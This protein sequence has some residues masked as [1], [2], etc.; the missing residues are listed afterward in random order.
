[1]KK[2]FLI[3][4][5]LVSAVFAQRRQTIGEPTD[6][7]FQN[8]LK[9]GT[10][11]YRMPIVKGTIGQW[12]QIDASGNVTFVNLD[13]TAVDTTKW[14][15]FIRDHETNH[16]AWILAGAI[17]DSL[18]AYRTSYK[19]DTTKIDTAQYGKFVR[20]H[21]SATSG[22][23]G[24]GDIE[25]VTAGWGI[26]GGGTTGTVTVTADTGANKLAT[27][28]D[29]SLKQNVSDTTTKDATRYWVGLQSYLTAETGDISNVSVTSPITGGGSSGSV[30]IG[31]DTTTGVTKLATQGFVE[32]KNYLTAETGDISN[33][34]VNAPITGGGSSGSVTISADTSAGANKLATQYYV[35]SQRPDSTWEKITVNDS[36]II[37]ANSKF[38]YG[39][40]NPF[41]SYID[42]TGRIGIGRVPYSYLDMTNYNDLTKWFLMFA[43]DKYRPDATD[44]LVAVVTGSGKWVFNPS[45][46]STAGD[47]GSTL[48]IGGGVKAD[49]FRTP[50]YKL[51]HADGSSG[52]VLVT[53]GSGTISFAARATAASIT[54]S[55]DLYRT[56]YKLDTTKIDT[57]QYGKFVRD[58]QSSGGGSGTGDI[59]GVTAGW[60]LSGGGTTG[61]VTLAADTSSGKL[62]THYTL[63]DSLNNYRVSQVVTIDSP[64]VGINDTSPTQALDVTG[65][66]YVSGSMNVAT[67]LGVKTDPAYNFH[68]YQASPTAN[69]VLL[70]VG[71]SDDAN[72]FGV[73]EDGDVTFDGSVTGASTLTISNTS[74]VTSLSGEDELWLNMDSDNNDADVRYIAFGKNSTAISATE[75]MRLTEAG[76]LGIGTTVPGA[77]V[78]IN[79]NKSSDTLL[80][81]RNDKV[82]RDSS[83][84][85]T[86]TGGGVFTGNVAI[87]TNVDPTNELYVNGDLYVV[88]TLYSGAVVDHTA[89]PE[90]SVDLIRSIGGTDGQLNHATLPKSIQ[91][92][93]KEERWKRKSDNYL[94]PREF[95]P[96]D[97]IWAEWYSIA[98]DTTYDT[99][100]VEDEELGQ[101][102][103]IDT[104]YHEGLVIHP[105]NSHEDSV[106]YKGNFFKFTKIDT[107]RDVG[108]MLSLLTKSVQYEF[109]NSDSVKENWNFKTNTL[110]PDT[111]IIGQPDSTY[112][113][114]FVLSDGE[115]YSRM[116]P[117]DA[118]ARVASSSSKKKDI[119]DYVI[120]IEKVK[121][122]KPKKYKYTDGTQEH[123]GFIA[124]EMN[125]A[126]GITQTNEIDYNSVIVA[127]WE[128]VRQQQ[129]RI[130]ALEKKVKP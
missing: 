29:I 112:N 116:L 97:S 24:T 14:G 2:I 17:K 18:D 85:V 78:E 123:T 41:Y 74:G 15:K 93:I 4:L 92:E 20:D 45:M 101:I 48:N 66:A 12:M 109:T 77:K 113:A 47:T 30:T 121:L 61:T 68:V 53:N 94:M 13:T 33:V 125:Q 64:F 115:A 127:L 16:Q 67:S 122:V 37:K 26:S 38:G 44:S 117:G 9:I 69:Q 58:H 35:L 42:S 62:A 119:T 56:A 81:V 70:N 23:S 22:G 57:A 5:I 11:T 79:G 60:G 71:T 100:Y 54:D 34:S 25:G 91:V 102:M 46:T 124:E 52:E 31:A 51:P 114:P 32:R 76:N 63:I 98:Y 72:R 107:G 7:L 90:D 8:Y 86:P 82:A 99:T 10:S 118:M 128:L 55:L 75:L 59:E 19:L 88:D 28:Y 50:H 103:K 40:Q 80:I 27:A 111:L 106:N 95:S 84:I 1:M 6:T 89:W 104:T 83:F 43:R 120:D 36:M 73:D 39:A 65:N 3:L 126:L 130:E 21:Q 110:S 49:T 96:V 105:A 108:A 129:E 87:A